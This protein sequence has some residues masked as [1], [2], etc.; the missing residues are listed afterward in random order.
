MD[1]CS[2]DPELD[3]IIDRHVGPRN[4]STLEMIRRVYNTM[5]DKIVRPERKVFNTKDLEDEDFTLTRFHIKASGNMNLACNFY[6]LQHL[7]KAGEHSTE[8]EDGTKSEEDPNPNGMISTEMKESLESTWTDS[9]FIDPDGEEE[10][11][12]PIGVHTEVAGGEKEG[13][14]EEELEEDMKGV[15]RHVHSVKDLG[16]KVFNRS[17]HLIIY[18]HTN[19]CSSLM[20]KEVLPI[21]KEM[22]ASLL[23]WD[24]RAHGTSDGETVTD[25][26]TSLLDLERVIAWARSQADKI[27]LWARGSSTAMAIK[28]LADIGRAKYEAENPKRDSPTFF[29]RMGL[30]SRSSDNNNKQKVNVVYTDNPIK[31]LVLDSPFLSVEKL[32]NDGYETVR[33][34]KFSFISKSLFSTVVSYFRRA[35]KSKLNGMDIFNIDNEED[36]AF[37]DVPA[38]FLIA[39]NDHYIPSKH[40]TDLAEKYG[41]SVYARMFDG[42]HFGKREKATVNGVLF[43]MQAS[44]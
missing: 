21:C 17:E 41:G 12:I 34:L 11:N 25:L 22:K 15:F 13:E 29:Q 31:Y 14:K 37:I 40:G 27:I 16:E 35:V 10:A 6:E 24:L 8:N 42:K 23:S 4:E 1:I 20:G 43:H 2:L 26:D 30:T 9:V 38:S 5:T 33:D 19:T 3:A 36:V 32:Y 44:L 18:I 28:Y 39:V 7:E